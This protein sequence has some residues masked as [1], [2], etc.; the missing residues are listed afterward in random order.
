[1][2][3][4][5]PYAFMV[6]MDVQADKEDLFNEVYDEEHIPALLKVDGVVA[7]SRLKTTPATLSM[8]GEEHAVTGEGLPHYIAIYEVESPD[9]LNSPA[10]A[11][12]VEAGRWAGQVRPFT[13]N[14][15]HVMR[16][17]I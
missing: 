3:F 9:V 5:A 7:V 2:P 13:T 17:L 10:W 15:Q 12:A 11:E 8:G 16:K 14:R 4:N 1:M 6:S